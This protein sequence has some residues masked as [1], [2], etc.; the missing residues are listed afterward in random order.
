MVRDSPAMSLAFCNDS[1]TTSR[2]ACVQRRLR[3]W[4]TFT[5][6]GVVEVEGSALSLKSKIKTPPPLYPPHKLQTPSIRPNLALVFVEL[7]GERELQRFL[8]ASRSRIMIVTVLTAALCAC[9][10]PKTSRS[11]DETQ[12]LS[13]RVIK[14]GDPVP[15]GGGVYK[16]GDPYLAGGKWYVPVNDKSYDEVGLASWYGD[17]FHGRRTANGE[18]Y[19]MAALTAAHPTLPLPTYAT[20]TNLANNRTV[21]VRIN[22]RGPYHDGRIIDLSHKAAELLGFYG[23]GTAAVRVRYFAPAPL[24]G[25]DHLERSILAR[26][27]WAPRVVSSAAKRKSPGSDLLAAAVMTADPPLVSKKGNFQKPRTENAGGWMAR[28]QPAMANTAAF[29]DGE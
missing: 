8:N 19:D 5:M 11:V 15:K 24:N 1:S 4:V 26:Q 18:I 6:G 13:P 25:D 22:D 23:H 29:K 7:P 16:L 17:F 28:A 10:V 3:L 27:P 20:V 12:T 9:S 14:V 2:Y 21:V